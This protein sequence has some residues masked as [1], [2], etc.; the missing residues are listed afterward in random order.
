MYICLY[1]YMI[2]YMVTCLCIYM[3][4]Y[5][6]VCMY[7]C[8]YVCI[9]IYIWWA[10]WSVWAAWIAELNHL[11]A[12]LN[13]PI[14]PPK[15]HNSPMNLQVGAVVCVDSARRRRAQGQASQRN[16][17]ERLAH[18]Q[19]CVPEKKRKKNSAQL[20]RAAGSFHQWCVSVQKKK[21]GK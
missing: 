19:R 10:L 15:P 9:Y 7:V 2:I 18:H 21:C 11:I 6:Y 20:T 17:Q 3:Y 12:E 1:I 14:S 13:N 8:M 5:V 16:R 4:V